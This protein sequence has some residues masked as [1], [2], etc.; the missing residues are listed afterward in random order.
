LK[1][2][3][4]HRVAIREGNY[5]TKTDKK[6][7]LATFTNTNFELIIKIELC[8]FQNPEI[9]QFEILVGRNTRAGRRSE[10]GE[11]EEREREREGKGRKRRGGKEWK[12]T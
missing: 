5:G 1:L 2:D 6:K 10:Q 3:F 7:N 9:V 11:G 12:L 8:T 4:F